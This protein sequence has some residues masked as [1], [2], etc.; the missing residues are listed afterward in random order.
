LLLIE[1]KK[2][3]LEI[4]RKTIEV[5]IKTGRKPNFEI[6]SPALCENKGVFV[7]LHK[8]GNLRGCIGYIEPVKPLWESVR[9]MAVSAST[10]D[11]RFPP[12]LPEELPDIDIEIS[13]LSPLKKISS[14]EEIEIGR[15]G[16][17]IEK[18]YSSGLL[19]PQVA[20]EYGWGKEE[21]L[22]H[23]C[24]KAGLDTDGWK[25]GAD[26]YIFSADIFSEKGLTK[27]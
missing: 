23:T 27:K 6:T 14:I 2:K 9:D 12:V 24:L 11:P 4:A 22:Q 18:G 19:L 1:E 13:A 5:Y 26:I 7:T 21:F 3:L 16:I 17:Y 20:T 25:K 15:D 8:K 10:Q